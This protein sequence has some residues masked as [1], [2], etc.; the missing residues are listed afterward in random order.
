MAKVIF[1]ALVETV[2]G[3]HGKGG[4]VSSAWK[5]VNVLKRHPMPRQPRTAAQQ[6]IRALMNDLSG[7]WYSLTDTQRELWNKY[8]SLLSGPYTGMNAYLRLNLNLARYLG[9]A[10]I[11]SAPP[12]S[13]STPQAPFGHSMAATDNVTNTLT[14][15]APSGNTDYMILEYSFLAALDDR[16]HP[17]WSFATGVSPSA[18][19]LAHTHAY[20]TGTIMSYRARVMDAYGR[21]SPYTERMDVTVPA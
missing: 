14:W 12:P 15:T 18:L 7:N 16:A 5:G 11:I 3:S 9:V 10:E 8:A 1:S 21:V 13:P 19:T 20:P 6:S 4:T 17:R 2:R